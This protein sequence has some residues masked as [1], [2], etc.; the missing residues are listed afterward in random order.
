ANACVVALATQTITEPTLLSASV[1]KTDVSCNGAS[2]GSISI[3]TPAGG[4]APYEFSVNGGTY[5]SSGSF[6]GLAAGTYTLAI[7]D[8]NSCVVALATQT[9]TEPTLLSASVSKTDVMCN[10]AST[11]SISITTP[12]GGVA[13]Y[14]F[15]VNGGAYQSSGS[16]TGL[17]AG[18]Y[19]L[20]IRDA[21][22]CVVALATQTITEPTLLSASVS[23][24][25]VLCNGAST[26]AISITSPVGGV[27]PYEYSVNG[28]AYQSSGS[29][30]GLAAGTYTLSIRDA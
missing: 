21:N 10:G 23:K 27:A 9:I 24:T 1:S 12:T 20:A 5:Q 4:V 6:T 26:G 28:G 3:T 30:T 18:T 16:F 29:F 14:E 22:A 17:V 13:P 15:S 11:G 19:T 25:D 2:T 8:A 7:R